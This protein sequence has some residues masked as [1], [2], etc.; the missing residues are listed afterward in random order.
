MANHFSESS[1]SSH[2][3]RERE[4]LKV[5]YGRDSKLPTH[6]TITRWREVGINGVKLRSIVSGQTSHGRFY[7]Y[8]TPEMFYEFFQAVERSEGKVNQTE[9]ETRRKEAAAA[10]ER[11]KAMENRGG[12]SSSNGGR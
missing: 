3:M 10:V 2:W 6:Q 7:R 1:N 9:E 4:V 11:I 5:V 8:Y 12:N